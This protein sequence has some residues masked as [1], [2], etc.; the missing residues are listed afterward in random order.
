M[1]FMSWIYHMKLVPLIFEP[2][3]HKRSENEVGGIFTLKMKCE[4]NLPTI[5]L[6][7]SVYV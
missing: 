2:F 6:P 1:H 5:I 4:I 7:N 3:M